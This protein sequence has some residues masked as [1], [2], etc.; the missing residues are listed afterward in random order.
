[1]NELTERQAE[2]VRF[3]DL[4]VRTHGFGPSI[5]DVSDAFGFVVNCASDH[6]A[7]A[8]AK[9]ALTWEPGK[10]ARTLR[11]APGVYVARSGVIGRFEPLDDRP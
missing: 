2:I 4:Y 5:R 1:M 11:L 7:R 3:V 9:G 8:K 6:L 10:R